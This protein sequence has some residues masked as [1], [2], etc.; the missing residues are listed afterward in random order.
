[1][2]C[3]CCIIR[4]RNIAKV[5]QLLYD[6]S[7][8]VCE[9]DNISKTISGCLKKSSKRKRNVNCEYR[10]YVKSIYPNT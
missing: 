2:Q 3:I 7:T 4:D 8:W 5:D 1:M 6:S 9:E 10:R